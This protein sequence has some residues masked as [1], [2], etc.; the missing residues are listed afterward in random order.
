MSGHIT[1][2]SSYRFRMAESLDGK[3]A[4]SDAYRSHVKKLASYNVKLD[5]DKSD[6]DIHGIAITSDGRRLL[7]DRYN[8]MI[9][10]FSRDMKSLCSLSLSTKPW[11]IA[12]TGDR[13]AFVSC[14]ET[15][16]LI[17]DIS[18]RKMSIK[19]TVELPFEVRGPAPYQ[20]KH[21][22]RAIAPYQDKLLVTAPWSTSSLNVKLIDQTG[23]VY[24]STHTHQQGQSSFYYP[25]Y[26]TCYDD[27][28]S[29]AVIVSDCY[30]NTLTVLNADTGD[31]I[32][33][34]QFEGKG[35]NGVTTDTTGNIYVCYYETD[36]VA[37][38]SKDLSQEKVLLSKRDGLSRGARAIVYNAV[39]HQLLVSYDSSD[40]RN[41]VDCFKL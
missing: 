20:D 5:D 14:D 27:G 21:T 11:D 18:D 3:H 9:K 26:V 30:N 13:K 33:R 6:C 32:N 29:A 2:Q 7:A 39:D 25:E 24:W 23:R 37:V 31:V 34:R 17:L 10:M 4:A 22:V 38:L 28:G 19:G 35:P 1:S 16:L 12:V 36:E 8:N 41:T 15:K 40:S